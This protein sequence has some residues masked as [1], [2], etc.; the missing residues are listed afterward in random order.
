MAVHH[1]L[2]IVTDGLVFQVDASNKLGEN[3]TDTKSMVNPLEIGTF[4]NGTTVVDG[5]YIFDGIDDY[6]GFGN[7]LSF[8]SSDSFTFSAWVNVKT[9]SKHKAVF[10]KIGTGEKGYQF[11]VT[12]A[13]KLR[14]IVLNGTGSSNYSD[15]NVL[16]AGWHNLVGI[17]D[18]VGCKIYIDGVDET[19]VIGTTTITNITTTAQFSVGADVF[20]SRFYS[21]DIISNISIYDKELTQAEISQNYE[22]QKHRFE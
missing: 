10:G 20:F 5:E 19:N 8:L 17:W 11:R 13:N 7:I 21:D 18:T 9:N 6:I 3:I 15:S 4:T 1:G 2:P 22:A 16:S 12:S 14:L